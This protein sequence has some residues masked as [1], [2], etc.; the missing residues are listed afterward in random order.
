MNDHIR[1]LRYRELAILSVPGDAFESKTIARRF[2][3]ARIT[4]SQRLTPLFN[5]CARADS[6]RR[7][8][9]SAR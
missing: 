3:T 5:P 8:S 6:Q 2:S 4:D 7:W 1:T 9:R